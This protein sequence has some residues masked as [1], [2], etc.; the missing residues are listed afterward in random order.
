MCLKSHKIS[1]V[2]NK[3]WCIISHLSNK[4]FDNVHHGRLIQ[5][6][7]IAVLVAPLQEGCGNFGK[8]AEE[9][10]RNDGWTRGD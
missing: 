8:G 4:A 10:Y 2:C 1:C 5:K 6:I 9:V 7:K 3:M